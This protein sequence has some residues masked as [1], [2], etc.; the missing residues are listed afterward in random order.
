[1]RHLRTWAI[2]FVGFWWLWLLL[3]GEWNAQE[4]VAAT[5]AA[6]LAS[7]AMTLARARIDARVRVERR[8]LVEARSVP[9]TVLVDFAIV[10]WALLSGIARGSIARGSLRSHRHPAAR[11][12]GNRWWLI[13][14]ATYSPNAY[15]VDVDPES[16]RVLLHD[17]VPRRSSE[18]PA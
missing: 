3:A 5:I 16:G 12:A 13:F 2:G 1:V 7:L 18:S 11:V 17:L 8:R 15:V 10:M 4:W 14:A 6:S 9:L